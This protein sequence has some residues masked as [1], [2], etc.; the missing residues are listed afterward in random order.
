[1]S[2][3]C[4]TLQVARSNVVAQ[5]GRSQSWV[6]GRRRRVPDDTTLL[7]DLHAVIADRPTNGYRRVAARV[8]R[9]RRQAGRSPAN[10]KA[11]YR[12][13][14]DHQLLLVR[15]TAKRPDRAHDGRV[16]V[17]TSNR[18]WCSDGFEI[19]CDNGQRVRVAFAQDC[20]DREAMSWVATTRGIDAAMVQ[21]LMLQAVESRFGNAE[22]VPEPIEWLTDNGSCYTAGATRSFGRTLGLDVKRTPIASPQSNGMAEAF[23][24]TFKRDYV[25]INP[26]PD[27]E[28]VM[29]QLPGWFD[30]YNNTHPHKALKMRSPREFRQAQASENACPV[31]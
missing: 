13:M 9:K 6:D 21:D 5:L 4:Q 7:A 14:R 8:N 30:D 23:V 16:A 3:V 29:R 11:V 22:R 1:M 31:L 20:C 26:R 2:A 15:H 17:E 28:A 10:H 18:R 12:V 27:A 24:K 19:A 25:A